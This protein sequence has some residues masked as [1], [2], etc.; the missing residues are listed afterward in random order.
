MHRNLL[1]GSFTAPPNLDDSLMKTGIDVQKHHARGRVL[2]KKYTRLPRC[3]LVIV[4]F[5][6]DKQTDR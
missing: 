3:F 4:G 1:I 5:G 2:V 6:A